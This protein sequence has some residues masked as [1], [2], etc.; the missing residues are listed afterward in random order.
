[1]LIMRICIDSCVFI[2]GIYTNAKDFDQI[3]AAIGPNCQ[4]FIPRLITL[5]VT[6][7]LRTTTFK[8][9]DPNSFLQQIAQLRNND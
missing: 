5:E 3:M 4:L 7:N 6:R 9:C 2:R 8:I 1:M